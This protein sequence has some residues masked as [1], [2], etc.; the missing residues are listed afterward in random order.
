MEDKI[1]LIRIS[2]SSLLS[3]LLLKGF[4]IEEILKYAINL[5]QT[6]NKQI[7]ATKERAE[8]ELET[9]EKL[10][11]EILSIK[12]QLYPEELKQIH[13][14]PV[15]LYAKGNLEL[16][17]KP[18]FAIVGARVATCESRILAENFAKELSEFGFTITSG[19]AYGVDTHACIGALKY[20][21]IQVL[22]SGLDVIY[23]KQ[24]APLYKEVLANN[25]LFISEIAPTLPAK[26]ENFP[27]RNRIISGISKGI[28]LVQASLK[29]GSSG[30]LI[31]AKIALAQEK[32]LFAIPSHPHDAK[33]EGGNNLL[34][35][36][37]AIFTTTP[38]DVIEMIGYHLNKKERPFTF[39]P[40]NLSIL[41]QEERAI[42]LEQ[43]EGIAKEIKEILGTNPTSPNEIAQILNKNIQEVQIAL[44]EMEIFGEVRKHKEGTFSAS[45][46]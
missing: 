40:K 30:S 32:D 15:I 3:G 13:N 44:M 19:F 29:N 17:K 12:H 4:Q 33:F 20:G 21:T 23:P 10:G 26:A 36:G 11:I 37:N 6:K 5:E 39:S 14:P 31:T 35:H 2:K 45:F 7:L 1:N 46:F 8:R 18:K 28:L 43:A 9:A 22:A 34:K 16:L 27:L 41:K 25:G 38:K 42:K 24:N